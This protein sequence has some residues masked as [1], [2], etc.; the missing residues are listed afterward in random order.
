METPENS[1]MKSNPVIQVEPDTT[2]ID[3]RSAD[4]PHDVIVLSSMGENASQTNEL[5][6]QLSPS[7][8]RQNKSK[9]PDKTVLKRKLSKPDNHTSPARSPSPTKKS[10]KKPCSKEIQRSLR[11]GSKRSGEVED[12]VDLTD[13]EAQIRKNVMRRTRAK[14]DQRTINKRSLSPAED[15]DLE[16]SSS[17]S[18]SPR[19]RLRTDSLVKQKNK[20][21][22]S[23]DRNRLSLSRRHSIASHD[24]L[25]DSSSKRS[26]LRSSS[27]HMSQRAMSS[28]RPSGAKKALDSDVM[29]RSKTGL[30]FLLKINQRCSLF[31]DGSSVGLYF[32][33]AII[34]FK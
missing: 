24:D 23:P 27:H 4:Q 6:K 12:T 9:S 2:V 1:P 5:K 15:S 26:H 7:K 29:T 11:F 10:P 28:S 31:I 17:P 16:H 14:A 25:Q 22:E 8:I 34:D 20:A 33:T 21:K 30:L 3:E 19:R 32:F 18:S 13:A